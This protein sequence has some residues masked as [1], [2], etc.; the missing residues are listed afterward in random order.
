[1]NDPKKG[2]LNIVGIGP[3]NEDYITPAS[4]RA[5]QEAEIV[6][7]YS[8]YIKLVQHLLSDKQIIRTGMTEEIRRAQLAIEESKKGKIVSIISSG[9]AGVY[10]MASLIFQ[11][12]EEMGW[13]K[14][15]DPEIHI[16]PGITAIN[17]C[18]SL[19]GAP[20]G[21]DFCS[22]SLSD[23]LTPW[24]IIR[25]RIELA[26]QADFVIGFYNPA[27]GR[28]Q[29]QIV[30]AKEI[31]EQYRPGT[32]PVALIKSAYRERQHIIISDLDHFLDYEIGMLTTVIVGNTNTRFFEG[33][34]Y[35][36]RGYTNK[37]NIIEGTV[38]PGQKPGISLNLDAIGGKND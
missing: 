26:A 7:G 5:I 31:I 15:D 13:K 36:P 25:K 9:D 6:I 30:E 20:L 16:Y 32:T 34:I 23:L 11:V 21:H 4:L 18:A 19:I 1:M 22:I 33:Y 24:P 3:G 37:Y 12:L 35:T 38:K 27:S 28:R 14:S 10:G 29:K 8:T 17:A 2:K